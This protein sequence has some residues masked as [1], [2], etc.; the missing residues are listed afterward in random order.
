MA[1][2]R[3]SFCGESAC[4]EVTKDGAGNVLVR[5]SSNSDV[6][7]VV[8]AWFHWDAFLNGIRLGEPTWHW[9][10]GQ[11]DIEFSTEEAEAFKSGVL[12]GQFHYD[13]LPR[14]DR[15]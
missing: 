4:L 6:D 12:A 9:F 8:F 13:R 5:N 1:W 7:P 15:D 10:R 3:S 11:D 2:K 14:I